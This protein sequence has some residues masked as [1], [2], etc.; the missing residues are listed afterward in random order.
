MEKT[1]NPLIWDFTTNRSSGSFHA[2]IAGLAICG[3]PWTP[4]KSDIAGPRP[5]SHCAC[6]QCAKLIDRFNARVADATQ[7]ASR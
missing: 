4:A 2:Y 5:P 6:R 1:E 3:V 7:V